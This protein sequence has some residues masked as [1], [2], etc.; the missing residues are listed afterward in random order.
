MSTR[1][2]DRESFGMS[3]LKTEFLVQLQGI[4]NLRGQVLLLAATNLPY[5]L[6]SA[7]RRRFDR[8]RRIPFHCRSCRHMGKP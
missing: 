3:G 8:V 5:Q 6:D 1:K 7:V 2:S 4:R